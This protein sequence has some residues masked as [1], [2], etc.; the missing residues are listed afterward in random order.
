MCRIGPSFDYDFVK[1]LDFG[2]A[3]FGDG[4][5]SKE[6]ELTAEGVSAGTPAFMAPEMAIG[7]REI[8]GR[9]DIYCL[10]CVG[11]WLVTGQRVFETESPLATVVAHVQER[12]VPPSQKTEL[13]IPAVKL[14]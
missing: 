6:T 4:R 14:S 13:E 3:K 1:V 8:D 12:P 7:D 9:A 11:Y 5:Q 10:G 2:I